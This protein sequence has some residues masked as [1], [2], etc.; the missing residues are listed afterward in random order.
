MRHL[1]T[2][3]AT[4]AYSQVMQRS[5]ERHL[6]AFHYNVERRVAAYHYNADQFLFF[7]RSA[8]PFPKTTPLGKSR[9]LRT[10][11]FGR[12]ALASVSL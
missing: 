1:L 4:P 11:S 7:V 9:S 6:A 5:L 8:K 2:L 12:N 3:D 10:A